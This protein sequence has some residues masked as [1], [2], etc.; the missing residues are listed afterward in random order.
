MQKNRKR[1]TKSYHAACVPFLYQAES[2][3][4]IYSNLMTITSSQN[5]EIPNPLAH[6]LK[7]QPFLGPDELIHTFL[8][9]AKTLNAI[10]EEAGAPKTIDLLSLDVEGFEIQVLR[11]L[12]HQMFRFKYI[13]IEAR[14]PELL[15]VVYR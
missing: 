3:Q 9:H 5:L 1:S 4:L 11:G 12:D 14:N 8:A 15:K 7:G 2:V 13:C 10:L 6:A